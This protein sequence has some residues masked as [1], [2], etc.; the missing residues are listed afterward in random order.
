MGGRVLEHEAKTILR[1][2]WQQGRKEG[3]KEGEDYGVKKGKLEQA[4]QTAF[5]LKAM[6][7]TNDS[8]AKAVEV[9]ISVIKEWFGEN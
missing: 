8:I 9:G 4:K 1:E 7:M 5:N 2:G 3:R 6:G